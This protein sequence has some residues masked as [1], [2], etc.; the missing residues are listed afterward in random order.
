MIYITLKESTSE[1]IGERNSV[2]KQK[3]Y[4]S[5]KD[6]IFE[7]ELEAK[8]YYDQCKELCDYRLNYVGW[9]T[10][11]EVNNALDYMMQYEQQVYG[12]ED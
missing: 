10:C 5:G 7:S 1:L 6:Y 4:E 12:W 2:F 8:S 11:Q 9:E 3:Y